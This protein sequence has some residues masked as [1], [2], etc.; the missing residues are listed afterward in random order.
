[1]AN[2]FDVRKAS[3]NSN[4]GFNETIEY[5]VMHQANVVSNHNKFYLLELQ[6]NPKGNYR[7]FTHYGRLGISNIYEIRDVYNGQPITD[8]DIIK[9]EFDGIHK[10]KLTGKSVPDP[11]NPGQKIKEAYVD[12]EVI[13]PLVG[14]ENI[15]GKA[16]T[17]KTVSIK[18]AI[19]TSTYDPTVSKLLDQLLEENI[20]SIT[21]QTSITYTSNGFSTSLGPVTPGHVAKAREPLDELNKLMGTKGEVDPETR[22]VQQLNSLF[23]S[24]IPKPFSRKISTDDMI[25]TA[26][27]LQDEYDLLTQLATGVQM[28]AA[29][30]GNTN[31]KMTALGADIEILKDKK[32]FDRIVN[33]IESS[34]A[35]NHR[36]T[37]VWY[38]KPKR[39][40]KIKIPDERKRYEVHY[41]NY[42]NVEEVYHGSS[43][44][45]IASILTKGLIVPP[46]NAAHVCG[47]MFYNGLY[48]AKNSSKSSNYSLGF[49][50]GKRSKYGNIFLF[51]ADFA[52]GKIYSTYNSEPSGPPRGYESI[53]AHKGKSLL[54]D[55]LIVYS[56]N[57]CT[58]KYLV[59]MSK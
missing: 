12:V 52:M 4:D 47:R 13:S 59:E 58:L 5:H 54:N 15:Q 8:F 40:F 23:F 11:D 14:S 1:M 55:E 34:K 39:V 17:K 25:Y 30:A 38:Y 7:I 35:S 16:E 32:E 6:K 57:Q 49:W 53:Y 31:Q 2:G 28:G 26:Q 33:N 44:S 22:E 42:G 9:K 46:V 56:L 51:I 3:D 24:L 27:K 43:N 20:H 10:K 50:G 45:N 36:N 29:M 18:T 19:D 37:D 41:T 48:G 21:S